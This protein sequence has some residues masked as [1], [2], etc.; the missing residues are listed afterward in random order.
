MANWNGLILLGLVDRGVFGSGTDSPLGFGTGVPPYRGLGGWRSCGH[1]NWHQAQ[2][3][4][5][6]V[7]RAGAAC[8]IFH[9]RLTERRTIRYDVNAGWSSLVARWAHNPKVVGSNPTPATKTPLAFSTLS[10]QYQTVTG[11]RPSSRPDRPFL[12]F[13]LFSAPFRSRVP[14]IPH[15]SFTPQSASERPNCGPSEAGWRL[16]TFAGRNRVR[17]G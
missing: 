15:Q 5:V 11:D 6:L 14:P 13:R 12:R 16:L 2:K 17:L 3:K 10:L 1:P 7:I 4:A 8:S 9:R